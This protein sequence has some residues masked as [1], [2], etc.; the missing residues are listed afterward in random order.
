[1]SKWVGIL[2]SSLVLV[3]GSVAFGADIPKSEN[4]AP[5]TRVT[6]PTAFTA[7]ILGRAGMWSVYF[8]QVLNDDISAGFGYGS[9]STELANGQDGEDAQ[10][11]PF[12]FNYYLKREAGSLFATAGANVVLNKKDVRGNTATTSDLEFKNSSVVPTVGFGYENRSDNGVL[13]RVAGYGLIG[14]DI[15]PWLGFSFGLAF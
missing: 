4:S 2:V 11:I 1:M 14:K 5:H 13:F 9:V 6:Y 7:E 10:M 3:T 8:D 12:Y 15:K